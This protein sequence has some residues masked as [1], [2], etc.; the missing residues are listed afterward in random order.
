MS[1][2]LKA[3]DVGEIT[4]VVTVN[5]QLRLVRLLA[6]ELLLTWTDFESAVATT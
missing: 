1:F 3:A 6:D 5:S 4:F 2:S